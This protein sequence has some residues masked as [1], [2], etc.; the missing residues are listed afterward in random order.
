MESVKRLGNFDMTLEECR[1]VLDTIDS[2]VVV[3]SE[4]R[5]KYLSPAMF[6][7]IEVLEGRR[8]PDDVV[9][10]HIE[11]IHPTSKICTALK[12]N[13]G[14][15]NCFY[16]S[17][18]ITNIARIKPVY[19]SGKLQGAIDYDIFKDDLDLKNFLDEIVDYS[20]KGFLNL[21]ETIDTIYKVAKSLDKVKYCVSDIIGESQQ[22]KELRRKIHSMSESES[23]V[24]IVGGTGCGKEL[25]AH[26]IHNISRRRTRQMVEINCA[27]IPDNLVES[28]LFGYE[29]GSFTGAKKGGKTG[30]FEMA[31]K[32]TIFLDEVDQLP[33]HVQPKL[34]RVLQ[35]KEVCPIGG[36]TIPINI[37]VIAATNKDLKELVRQGKFREDLYYRLNVVEIRVPPLNE[38]LIDIPL[39]ANNQLKNLNK[40]TGKNVKSISREVMELLMRHDWPGNVRQLNNILERAV[41]LCSGDVLELEHFQ[42]FVLDNVRFSADA[43]EGEDNPLEKVRDAAEKEA[44]RCALEMSGGNRSQTARLLKISRTGLYYKMV[45]YGLK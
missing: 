30:K 45:K 3:D 39:L 29:E 1:N 13:R 8:A 27:A 32:G 11:E 31:D 7:V 21:S 42:D 37:R 14:S 22:I 17:V 34:L 19:V 28:E 40:I 35:E 2:L 15:R 41:N 23:T 25:V 24:M 16:F 5:I 36:K 38:R 26:S 44:I 12:E 6:D 43:L 20:L 33:W 10:R 18:G 4:G 9:G